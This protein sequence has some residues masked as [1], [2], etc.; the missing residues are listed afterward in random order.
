MLYGPHGEHLSRGLCEGS[1]EKHGWEPSERYERLRRVEGLTPFMRAL[2][3]MFPVGFI[4]S[5]TRKS[6]PGMFI[7]PTTRQHAEMLKL[8]RV[9]QNIIDV[10][11]HTD[12]LGLGRMSLPEIHE[13][14]KPYL[15]EYRALATEHE[16][17]EFKTPY[18]PP[19]GN[20]F[21]PLIEPFRAPVPGHPKLRLYKKPINPEELLPAHPDLFAAYLASVYR[22]RHHDSA[23]LSLMTLRLYSQ[24]HLRDFLI[25]ELHETYSLTDIAALLA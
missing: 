19:S 12:A 6:F 23:D 2:E 11:G 1:P 4:D 9:P 7:K 15:G 24:P 21:W 8:R 25:R 18:L 10:A 13:L 14:L 20:K 16:T 3:T 17:L 5:R 22:G